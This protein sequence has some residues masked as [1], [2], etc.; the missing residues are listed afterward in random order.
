MTDTL[1]GM[2]RAVTCK[3]CGKTTW[4]GCGQHVDS[5]KK[6]VPAGQ[7]CPGHDDEPAAPGF[8]GKLFGWG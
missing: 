3:T 7:W 8:F 1:G 4:A 2:C 6:T 5:V